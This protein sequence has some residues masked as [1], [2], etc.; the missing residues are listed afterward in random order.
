MPFAFS[1][2]RPHHPAP[3]RSA[4]PL[5]RRRILGTRNASENSSPAST[6][7]LL[8]ERAACSNSRAF[9]GPSPDE[10]PKRVTKSSDDL[11][12][13]LDPRHPPPTQVPPGATRLFPPARVAHLDLRSHYSTKGRLHF[14]KRLGDHAPDLPRSLR[15][16]ERSALRV[17]PH[18]R[19]PHHPQARKCPFRMKSSDRRMTFSWFWSSN[20]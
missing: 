8:I 17:S 12:G 4:S 19:L 9:A 1:S 2:I 20:R 3:A 13:R 5:I 18:H 10:F 6:H 16:F 14:P 7:P 11:P 15:A